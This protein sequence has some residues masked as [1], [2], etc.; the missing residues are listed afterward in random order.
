M[1]RQAPSP[2]DRPWL[3]HYPPDVPAEIDTSTIRSLVEMFDDSFRRFRDRTAV[4]FMD[5]ELS[6]GAI[7]DASRALAAF[8][9]STGMAR[10]SRVAVMMPNVPQYPVA[11]VAIL[12][13]GFVVERQSA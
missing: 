8:L 5:K 4:I 2:T 9:Q 13:A 6:Y 1:N 11:T 7:D 10:G 12:R 3:A